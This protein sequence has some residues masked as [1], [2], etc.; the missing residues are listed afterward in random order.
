MDNSSGNRT[1]AAC[2]AGECPN[3]PARGGLC[4]THIWRRRHGKPM[5]APLTEARSRRVK[6]SRQELLGRAAI[7]YAD[8][9]EEA[10]LRRARDLIRK[11][12][13]PR[14]K[15]AASELFHK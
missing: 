7:R 10:E 8:A 5:A 11:H 14:R 9:E 2:T 12:A 13:L 15:Q 4:W 3:P 6:L 1:D